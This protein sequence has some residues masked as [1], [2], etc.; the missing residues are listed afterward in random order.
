MGSLSVGQDVKCW[1]GSCKMSLYHTILSMVGDKVHK[2]QCN[3]CKASHAF[4]DA[5]G[6]TKRK[7]SSLANPKPRAVSKPVAQLWK[8]A[9]ETSTKRSKAY[10]IREVFAVGDV[11]DHVKFGTGI[12]QGL[13]DSD[14]IEVM[15]QNDI[16]T[17]VHAK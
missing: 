11:I 10:S 3:T 4:R 15:F 8:E 9:L 6:T 16:K 13:V 12:V 17:L 14:K 7:T 5:P 2:V 1:C